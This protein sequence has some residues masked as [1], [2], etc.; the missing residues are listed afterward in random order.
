MCALALG[1]LQTESL[2]GREN[3]LDIIR[4]AVNAEGLRVIFILGQAGMGKTRLL[5]AVPGLAS[6]QVAAPET[7]ID[8]YH[9]E[10]HTN[11]G[12]EKAIAGALDAENA[13]FGDYRTKRRRF[14]RLRRAGGD[15][16]QLETLRQELGKAFIAN[17][18]A[19]TQTRRAV[20]R[21]DTLELVQSE[22]TLHPFFGGPHSEIEVRE[23]LKT[24]I[25]HMENVVVILAGRPQAT[26]WDELR[27]TLA[28]NQPVEIALG[29]LD[30]AGTQAYFEDLAAGNERLRACELHDEHYAAIH[31]ATGGRPLHL[32]F[33]ATLLARGERAPEDLLGEL[34]ALPAAE[35]RPRLLEAVW[36]LTPDIHAV[37]SYVALLRKGVSGPLL[38]EVM[39]DRLGQGWGIGKTRRVLAELRALPFVKTRPGSKVVFLHDELYDLMD[40]FV[41]A[42]M[43]PE[44]REAACRIAR[45]RYE[46]KMKGPRVAEARKQRWT[47]EQL[48]YALLENPEQGFVRYQFLSDEA[49]ASGQVG[50]EMALRDEMLRFFQPQVRD[51]TGR[52]TRWGQRLARDA[53]TRWVQRIL[54]RGQHQ[55]ALD[56]AKRILRHAQFPFE[57]GETRLLPPILNA[58]RG[59]ALA[60][61]GRHAEAEQVLLDAIDTLEKWTDRFPSKHRENA[62]RYMLGVAH[63]NLGHVYTRLRAYGQV[64]AESLTA[65]R[66]LRP[67][68]RDGLRVAQIEL[69]HTQRNLAYVYG[70]RGEWSNAVNLCEKALASFRTL[71]IRWGEALALNVYGTIEA[72]FHHPHRARQ[73][74]QT[75]LRI[76]AAIENRR[77][78]GLSRLALGQAYRR[79]G[80]QP[81]YRHEPESERFFKRARAEL[82]QARAIFANEVR[83]PI[84]LAETIAEQGKLYRDWAKVCRARGGQDAARVDKLSKEAERLLGQAIEQANANDMGVQGADYCQDLAALY[85]FLKQSNQAGRMLDQIE[86]R[87]SRYVLSDERNFEGLRQ[88]EAPGYLEVLGKAEMTHGDLAHARGELETAGAAWTRAMGYF[89]AYST[90]AV[91]L[92]EEVVTGIGSKLFDLDAGTLRTLQARCEAERAHYGLPHTRLHDELESRLRLAGGSKGN[93][94]G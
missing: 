12:I 60:Y 90:E 56:L 86:S 53:A 73:R 93:G 69:A 78:V 6:E 23:W 75:A 48:Y 62:R 76:F 3:E 81:T 61:L 37:L 29:P 44:D 65:V 34:G 57:H 31:R 64:E 26:L 30:Q 83:E 2:I 84:R 59:E 72:R 55:A 33:M 58:Y 85:A 14:E 43:P 39:S 15:P 1:R 77:G 89:Y 28:E 9:V 87:L 80:A 71:G 70:E 51:Q 13:F 8:L 67:L 47:V 35:N 74:C 46:G 27:Q 66:V 5:N 50:Y 18:N 22:Q 24:H 49:L 42:D 94:H 16:K 91:R 25:P 11:S 17:L 88:A 36:T 41:L 79:L 38:K 20:L 21:F 4:T 40:E 63:K 54:R 7:L 92:V 68:A 45:D 19:C 82:E 32:A 10:N 52:L